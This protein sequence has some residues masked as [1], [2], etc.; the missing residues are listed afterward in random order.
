MKKYLSFNGVA[1]RSEYWGVTILTFIAFMV[2]LAIG[3][4]LVA[5]GEVAGTILG[6]LIVLA[7]IVMYTWYFLAVTVKR[8]RD[9][10]INPWWTASTFIPYI[11]CIPWIVFGCLPTVKKDQV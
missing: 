7:S 2:T 11:G 9:A 4:A 10:D 6:G 1:T 5:S 3:S 8:C